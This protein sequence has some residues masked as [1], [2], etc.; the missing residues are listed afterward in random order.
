MPSCSRHDLRSPQRPG[1]ALGVQ[2]GGV[3]DLVGVDV[4]DAG[5]HVLVE[6]Q[7][8]EPG[9][10][11]GEQ[12]LQRDRR[13]GRRRS[14]SM[15]SFASSGSS[16]STWSGSNT[17]TSPNVRGST[18]HSSSAG[19][20]GQRHARRGCAAGRVGAG[21]APAAA[22]RS[23]AGAPSACR[24]CRAGSSRYLPRRSAART[25]APVSPSID[26]LLRRP[27]HR[28]LAADLDVLDARARR[29]G[30]RAR[31]GRSRPRGAQAPATLAAS[32]WAHGVG[33]RR[34]L[35]RLLRAP[36][37]LADHGAVD[38]DGGEEALG[39]VGAL[40]A[41]DVLGRRAAVDGDLLLQPRLVVEVVE[42]GRGR[43]RGAGRSGARSRS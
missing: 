2:L 33:R 24:R 1:D 6:Q 20:A 43:R 15:P 18:N 37:A 16:T 42:V 7:R 17:T 21:R 4:A 25:V 13:R 11:A 14:G 31:A 29:R 3:Q 22:G 38:D 35:G 39:V 23:C 5:D 36:R 32:R 40:G 19:V 9:A 12:R 34:L 26:L 28:P 27:P 10:A 30:R 8:L 41:R